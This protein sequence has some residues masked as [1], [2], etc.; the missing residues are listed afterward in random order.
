MTNGSAQS[1]K[2]SEFNKTVRSAVELAL[3]EHHDFHFEHMDLN[4]LE[5]PGPIIFG[6]IIRDHDVLRRSAADLTK[7][8]QT[9]AT[10]MEG[11][12]RGSTPAVLI[13]EGGA[14]VG[15]MPPGPDILS[16][17]R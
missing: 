7:V 2:L 3:K 1:I 14:T 5:F 10:K 6:F 4:V 15:F 9:V 16:L 8:A 12:S 17:D 11:V 13:R